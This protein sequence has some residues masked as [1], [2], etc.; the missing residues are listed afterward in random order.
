MKQLL[1]LQ[2]IT[3][4]ALFFII[5][6]NVK[7][8]AQVGIGTANPDNSA[9]L[10][11]KSTNRGFLIP[12]MTAVQRIAISAPAKG[13]MV[14]DNDSTGFFYFDGSAWKP[15]KNANVTYNAG[16]GIS[17]S[18]NTISGNYSAGTGISI[19]GSTI[20]ALN[21]SA[22][23]NASQIQGKNIS[24]ATPSVNQVLK[25]NGTTWAPATDSTGASI[26][27]TAGTGISLS[28]TTFSAQN[29]SALW[30][31][32]QLQGKTLSTTAPSSGQTLKWNGTSWTPGNDSTTAYAAGT[33]LN[34][35]G[36]TFSA[37]NTTAQW[38]ANKL[39]GTKVGAVTP[40][41]NQ[42]LKYNST[43]GQWAPGNDTGAYYSAG[44]GVSLSG[45]TI[46]ANTTSALWNA[47][48]LQG[49]TVSSTAPSSGQ[50]LK[51]NG[52]SW[53]P[54]ND[55][56]ATY[57]AGNGVTISANKVSLGGALSSATT[58]GT[59]S[60]NTLKLT[61][62]QSGANTDS[63]MVISSGVV[64]KVAQS[65][66]AG[67]TYTAGTGVSISGTTINAST[68]S[69]LWNASQLQGRTLSATAPSSGQTLKWNGTS[70]TPGNDS[71]VTYAAGTG[72]SISSGT[73]NTN[74]T[75]SST[76]I[77]N[78]NTGNIGVGN[79]SPSYK[80]DVNGT[81]RT[82]K[83]SS[84]TGSMVYSNSSNNNTVTINS[85]TTSTSYT[86]TLPTAQGSSNTVLSN[87]GSGNLSWNSVAAVSG[88]WSTSGNSS[89]SS[90]TNFI[91]TKD[92]VALAIRTNNTQVGM[93]GF[94]SMALG[95][96][97]TIS[98][99][100]NCYVIGTSANIGYNH[101]AGF[102]FG[103]GSSI[104]SDS[105][106]A[107]GNAASVNG[108]GSF[109]IGNNASANNSNS[110]AIGPNATTAYSITNALAMGQS[111]SANSDSSFAI[112]VKSSTNGKNTISI[113]NN[114]SANS[115]Y[116]LAIGTKAYAAWS[117]TDAMAIGHGANANS[118]TSIALGSTANV[119]GK[120][121]IA[122]G[123]NAYCNSPSSIAIG[124]NSS[125]A[126]S[127]KDAT[128]IG[129]N[130][131]AGGSYS[132][133]L[134]GAPAGSKTQSSGTYSIAMGYNATAGASGSIAIGRK[135]YSAYYYTTPLAIG[136]SAVCNGNYSIAIGASANTG[137]VSNATAIGYGAT[138][139]ASNA[140]ALGYG[141]KASQSNSIIL[142]NGSANVG[143]G[144]SSPSS[145]A[146][147]DLTS[148][149]QGALMPRMTT[150][151]RKAI[152]S[153][154]TGLLVFD[155]TVDSFYVYNGT[156]WANIGGNT[157]TTTTAQWTT[158][159][160]NIYNANSGNV[161]IG[162]TS[163]SYQ[164]DVKGPVNADSF[165][166]GGYVQ[167]NTKGS[168]NLFIGNRAGLVTT[169][170]TNEFIGSQAGWVN[171]TGNNNLFIGFQTAYSN[172]TGTYNEFVGRN[173]GYNNTT[174][175]SNFFLGDQAGY[176]N[177]TGSYNHFSGGNAGYNNTTGNNNF[178]EGYQAGYS[179]TTAERNLGIG[180]NAAYNNTTGTHNTVIGYQAG[181]SNS[182]GGYNVIMGYQAGYN[183]TNASN[184][185]IGDLAGYN[186][187]SGYGNTAL[188]EKAGYSYNGT[189]NTFIGD[190]ADA[191]TSGLVNATAIG[192]NAK[193]AKSN[194]L[195]L[196][197][198]GTNAVNVGIGTTSPGST[199]TVNGGLT[200]K[201]YAASS[202]YTAT[203][204]DYI[205]AATSAGL[206]ITLPD[207]TSFDAGRMYIIKAEYTSGTS[208]T[209]ATTSSQTIDGS[210]TLP[211]VSQSSCI[212]LYSDGKNWWTF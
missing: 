203:A 143:I 106:F 112:G 128:A 63:V 92:S 102:A 187:T 81:I 135:A 194:T 98:N 138:A 65:S 165:M 191:S 3:V 186:N 131:N 105:D 7:S 185:L 142:G 171:T 164:L 2:K 190:S 12:R 101:N 74:W 50:T 182:T 189:H 91:G 53:T 208:I 195:I 184:V 4:V 41:N 160:S 177:T 82:G 108:K 181:Y 36:A 64:K 196:G 58:I 59:S 89:T 117:T 132:I 94:N 67:T 157:G 15:L 172:T 42:V 136:D 13:L 140:T 86:L 152:S 183:T 30:N 87:D 55:S 166:L 175:G 5:G 16:T 137:A 126:W 9:V 211:K 212:R 139:T 57:T 118:D 162:K 179:N 27:Y 125:I 93:I 116:D 78:N 14:F 17:I 120:S 204:S 178:Y 83:G 29:T 49:K 210:S 40:T 99:S 85:G 115:T 77:Y 80:M 205:I 149:T 155:N 28:G 107:I 133:A 68:T 11:L 20:A 163:P 122:I 113:G 47:N 146:I 37:Q 35:S 109:A 76:N 206:T 44:T 75:T 193:A 129:D 84:T 21:T 199:L 148:T 145:T 52:T 156:K 159:G 103:N 141:A 8:Y 24:T 71:V 48:Q 114:A 167:L 176:K 170:G 39:Q 130:A 18:G 202:N 207:A 97:S 79:T 1:H 192:Y 198:T 73:I 46:N 188:G 56:I 25:W 180:Y 123:N 110:F 209:L 158:S 90:S 34:L 31:A 104:S 45:T 121:S 200:L 127:I 169:G 70:W 6:I 10:E 153:P 69:A 154:A 144:T 38:N 23:W 161:A 173:A 61:G 100:N 111:A 32:N 96:G 43:S 66:I 60:T 72:V 51:W 124:R 62:V 168:N 201:R 147:L 33:G 134:G 174:G 22:K 19:S 26:T 95:K 54:G 197:G 151:Q 88:G 119:N 150:T